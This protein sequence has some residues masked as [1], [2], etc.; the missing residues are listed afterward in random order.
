MSIFEEV[1]RSVATRQATECCGVWV[2]QNGM[3]VYPFYLVSISS[4]S[5]FRR[6]QEQAHTQ[7]RDRDMEWRGT[8]HFLPGMIQ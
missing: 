4:V 6:Q 3:C 2:G 1:K 7:R 8:S 5:S